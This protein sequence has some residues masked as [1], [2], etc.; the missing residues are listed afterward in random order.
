MP[1][2][3]Q[4]AGHQAARRRRMRCSGGHASCSAHA[5]AALPRRQAR[6]PTGCTAAAA[7]LRPCRQAE[8]AAESAAPAAA[9][10]PRARHE[11]A[12]A[13]DQRAGGAAE[14]R[15]VRTPGAPGPP[16]QRNCMPY[17]A[18]HITDACVTCSR[19]RSRAHHPCSLG[20]GQD[21]RAV[22]HAAQRAAPSGRDEFGGIPRMTVR[23]SS[24]DARAACAR[25]STP[26]PPHSSC[27]GCGACGPPREA[28]PLCFAQAV[29]RE[30][31]P[32]HGCVRDS[33]GAGGHRE[34][35]GWAPCSRPEPR[36][37]DAGADGRP[38]DCRHARACP[39][40]AG[41]LEEPG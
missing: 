12:G 16:E 36:R 15:G 13:R 26:E 37:S 39:G 41:P 10:R 7:R 17:A 5:A 4:C 8:S 22:M 23:L 18:V 33:L 32:G 27:L 24:A 19:Q 14:R 38:E 11:P 31:Q 2:S 28:R 21:L 25:C 34:G 1:Q 40:E 29:P 9:R 6:A 20:A 30:L 35:V 3:A